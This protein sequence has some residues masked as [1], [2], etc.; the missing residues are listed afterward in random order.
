MIT[1]AN[2]PPNATL[3]VGGR[4]VPADFKGPISGN[5]MRA[6]PNGKMVWTTASTRIV[7]LNLATKQFTA[8]DIPTW[9]EKKQN[10]GAYG[11]DVATYVVAFVFAVA[12]N[13][14]SSL[15]RSNRRMLST[16]STTAS[17]PM[18]MSTRRVDH[19]AP[20]DHAGRKTEPGRVPEGG[21]LAGRLVARPRPAVEILERRGI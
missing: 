16:I 10:P 7:G 15:S 20:L 13:G 2:A 18:P 17:T 14:R 11:I 4:L 12:C 5:F 1:V 21:D 19:T 6:D 9:V 8:Y 3:K